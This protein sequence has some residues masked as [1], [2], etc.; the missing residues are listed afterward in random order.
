MNL[1]LC[2]LNSK[3]L[4]FWPRWRHRS[5]HCTSLHN[6][7]KDNNLKSKK[8]PELTETRTVWKSNKEIK[9]KHSPRLVGGAETGSWADRTHGKV[10]AGGPSKVVDMGWCEQR[11]S[12]PVKQQLVDQVTD[13]A[14][15]GSR[16]IKPQTSD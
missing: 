14:T 16:E 15:Q 4:D 2:T 7:K 8:Q 12:W 11:C 6:Q 3:W 5:T 13:S 9:K 1:S 10:V